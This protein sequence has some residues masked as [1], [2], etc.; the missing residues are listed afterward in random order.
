M[1]IT[2]DTI[3]RILRLSLKQTPLAF[4]AVDVFDE[5]NKSNNITNE[6]IDKAFN[7]LKE[8]SILL[9]ELQKDLTERTE[10]VSKL[11]ND[12][13]HYSK[14]S[15]IE[16]ENIK[17]ILLELSKTVNKGKGRERWISFAINI[18]AGILLFILGV[19]L[20]PKVTG[21]FNNE[22]T[23]QQIEQTINP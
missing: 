13:E 4:F 17:P 14:L 9:E 15:E 16:K 18:I 19:W 3:L 8:T 7:S 1:K 2:K 12:Y 21:L 10:M 20:S 23:N 6:K 11:K 5:L 22:K